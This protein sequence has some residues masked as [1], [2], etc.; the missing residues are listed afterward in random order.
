MVMTFI[1]AHSKPAYI[2][3]EERGLGSDLIHV[4]IYA[5]HFNGLYYAVVYTPH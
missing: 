3:H 1:R 4:H 2:V 5:G